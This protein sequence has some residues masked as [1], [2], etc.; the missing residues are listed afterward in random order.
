MSPFVPQPFE[1]CHKGKSKDSHKITG[2]RK[3]YMIFVKGCQFTT[4]TVLVPCDEDLLELNFVNIT[5]E[6][7]SPTVNQL[8]REETDE[9]VIDTTVLYDMIYPGTSVALR[10][11]PESIESLYIL[12]VI[13]KFTAEKNMSDIYGQRVL[14]SE[15]CI[16]GYCLNR[17]L[18]SKSN[19]KF[20]I[21]KN[22]NLV[23]A[24][25]R[26]LYY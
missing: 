11:P 9:E 16:S 3:M 15:K 13:E 7:I 5:E 1:Q 22:P 23:C 24:L 18:E 8:F 19:V 21:T 14:S 2:C 10:S 25:R 12:K 6:D 20:S 4:K 26:N 17:V